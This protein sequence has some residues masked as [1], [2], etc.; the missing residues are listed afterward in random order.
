M[1][2]T[3]K[4][5]QVFEKMA[6]LTSEKTAGAPIPPAKTRK[7]F[8]S[9]LLRNALDMAGL[10]SLVG[11]GSAAASSGYNFIKD[12]V[13]S[14]NSYKQM[15]NEFPELKDAPRQQVDKY[16]QILDD[17]APKLTTNPL[18]A[19]QFVSN[20]M[21]YGMR[22][23]DHNTIGQLASISKDINAQN[24]SRNLLDFSGR[25]TLEAMKSPTLMGG[26]TQ[27]VPDVQAAQP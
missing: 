7:I 23:V 13:K 15:F 11:I 9:P 6:G 25:V 8:D 3:E 14:H 20:M 21:Q 18:V 26:L 2:I 22:G 10:L 19:G 4:D 5:I 12:K 1:N 16:W 24:N 27:E 17:F